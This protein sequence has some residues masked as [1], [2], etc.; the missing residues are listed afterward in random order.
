MHQHHQHPHHHA[1]R[2]RFLRWTAAASVL[3]GLGSWMRAGQAATGSDYKAL[4]CVFLYGGNDG[5]NCIVPSDDA[6]YAQYS[7]VR[8]K[9]ALPQNSLVGLSGVNYGLHPALQPLAM[10]WN[11]GHL[12]PVFNVG[13]LAQPLTQAQYLLAADPKTASSSGVGLPDSLFSHSD[14]QRQWQAA[15]AKSSTRTGWG[16]R[17][18]MGTSKATQPV[19]SFGGNAFFG[20]SDNT[21]PLV[22]PSPGSD[23]GLNLYAQL[24]SVAL[25]MQADEAAAPTSLL[26]GLYA[27]QQ[28]AAASTA[29]LLHDL[30]KR[31]PSDAN[32]ADAAIN[33]AFAALTVNGKLSTDFAKQMYQIAKFIVNNAT[34]GGSRQA[35]FARMD[36]F[37]LHGSQVLDGSGSAAALN[38]AGNH[39]KLLKDLGDA[40]GAFYTAMKLT[41]MLGNVTLFTESDFGRTFLPNNTLGT[42]HAWGNMHFVL[43]GAV[44]GGQTYGTYPQLV[45]GG[46]DDV[47]VH[48]WDMQG[49][50][51][52]TTSVQQYA[53]TLLNWFLDAPSNLNTLLPGLSNFGGATNL[54]FV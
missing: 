12:A 48:S 54:G 41:G 42:D 28:N 24:K 21:S 15:S 49:R 43:G 46:P 36:G 52:P 40:L 37:D 23:F 9:L 14:Q 53:A 25:S 50:W 34:V 11:E 16:G 31:Q 22:L 45:L 3:G 4:V 44:K 47:G 17:A 51:I 18:V 30:I 7:A 38:P 33:S 39:Y 27:G 19:I 13:P 6:R 29:D 8:Q 2:R 5:M 1:D 10:A 20:L 32:A 26:R 35:Y